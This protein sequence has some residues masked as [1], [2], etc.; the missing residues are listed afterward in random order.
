VFPQHELRV[1][2]ILSYQSIEH[3]LPQT[4]RR[5]R[6]TD[7]ERI[8]TLPLFAGYI[9]FRGDRR[10]VLRTP[11][12]RGVLEFGGKPAYMSDAEIDQIRQIAEN[13]QVEAYGGF[14][15]GQRVGVQI[16]KAY[17]E[18]VL[19]TEGHEQKVVVSYEMLGRKL[20]VTVPRDALVKA[21]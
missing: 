7:R 12:V 3:Y 18:G 16:G 10:T 15:K 1:S 20:A 19:L 14:Q 5:S 21:A 9:F 4:V 2:T 6:W 13:T 11:S 17:V 8:I